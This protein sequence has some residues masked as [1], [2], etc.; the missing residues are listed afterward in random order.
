MLSSNVAA[1]EWELHFSFRA[2][3]QNCVQVLVEWCCGFD[4]LQNKTKTAVKEKVRIERNQCLLRW[5]KHQFSKN[6][7]LVKISWMR[8]FVS[9]RRK[10]ETCVNKGWERSHAGPSHFIFLLK[11]NVRYF[12]FQ[13]IFKIKNIFGVRKKKRK[14]RKKAGSEAL[15]SSWKM[16]GVF[17]FT[18]AQTLT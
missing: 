5:L 8:N 15:K 9:G 13:E 1:V 11:R 4:G 17:F 7:F 2:E 10:Q 14:W 16:L 6:L 12:F 18:I 3:R